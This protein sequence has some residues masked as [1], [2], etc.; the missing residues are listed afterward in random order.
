MKVTRTL[1]APSEEEGITMA[2]RA[3]NACRDWDDGPQEETVIEYLRK[4][5]PGN[6]IRVVDTAVEN[7]GNGKR[8]F[9]TEYDYVTETDYVTISFPFS[10]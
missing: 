9:R 1:L 2:T 7:G 8:Y 4:I 10:R 3:W 5:F 6:V